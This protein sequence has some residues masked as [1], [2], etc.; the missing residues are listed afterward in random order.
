MFF[1]GRR[2]PAPHMFEVF[3]NTGKTDQIPVSCIY[4][5]QI[6]E[7]RFLRDLQSTVVYV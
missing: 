6:P 3:S 5:I 1:S 7:F 2:L 4:S